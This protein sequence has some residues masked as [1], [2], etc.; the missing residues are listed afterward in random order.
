MN[1]R[2]LTATLNDDKALLAPGLEDKVGVG[3]I[4]PLRLV[5]LDL[6][7]GSTEI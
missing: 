6:N 3:N 2:A 1:L 5:R 7:I 4:R